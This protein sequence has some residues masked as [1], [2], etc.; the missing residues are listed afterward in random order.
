M[1]DKPNKTEQGKQERVAEKAARAK[2][3]QG[4]RD[5]AAAAQ[6]RSEQ[7]QGRNVDAG[8][9]GRMASFAQRE[10]NAGLT[11]A[12]NDTTAGRDDF[13]YN[14][15]KSQSSWAS[16]DSGE[17]KAGSEMAFKADVPSGGGG[18][19]G[20][21]IIWADQSIEFIEAADLTDTY[22]DEAYW[23]LVL[24]VSSGSFDKTLAYDATPDI[25]TT[26]GTA[27]DEV[28]TKYR[29]RL[30]TQYTNG[31]GDDV[32]TGISAYGQYREVTTCINGYPR[33]RLTK[34]T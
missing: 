16:F 15:S 5:S 28:Q 23:S 18:L 26:T 22:D 1:A 7:R 12:G 6:S 10:A 9:A 4:R 24:T 20:I 8:A 13:Y 32:S 30:I 11:L 3:T 14:P 34:V 29:M 33:Q 2:A 21:E 19:A 25:F 17:M 27:P 31:D